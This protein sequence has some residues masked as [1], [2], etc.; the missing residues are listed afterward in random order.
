MSAARDVDSTMS[1]NRT[2][3]STRSGVVLMRPSSRNRRISSGICVSAY[4]LLSGAV[5]STIS[6]FGIR[7]A[8]Y[9]PPSHHSAR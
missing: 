6:A 2:V 8:M 3:V 7:S 5:S 1:V 9:W 4:M